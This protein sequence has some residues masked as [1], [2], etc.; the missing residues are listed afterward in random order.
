MKKMYLVLIAAAMAVGLSS[1]TSSKTTL[2]GQI[3]YQDD[4]LD[5]H[6]YLGDPCFGTQIPECF[7]MTPDGP[8][9]L[10][11]DNDVNQP[12]ERNAP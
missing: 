2:S 10:F 1:F 9:Q 3:T 12:V 6:N 5:W 8:R 7:K 11:Y 4:N